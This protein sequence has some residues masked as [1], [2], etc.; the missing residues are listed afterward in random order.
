MVYLRAQRNS[1]YIRSTFYLMRKFLLFTFAIISAL[2]AEAQSYPEGFVEEQITE[3]IFYP[4]GVLFP[5]TNLVMVW[6]LNGKVWLL[7]N[8][9]L[10]PEPIIDLSE[11]VGMWGDH[12]MIGAAL[13]PDFLNNGWIYLFYVVDRHYLMYHG[14][15]EYDPAF[16]EEGA[17]VMGRITRFTLSTFDFTFTIPGSRKIIMG[18]SPGDGLPIPTWSHGVG[19]LQFGEDGSLLVS[20]GD[21]NTWVG[22]SGGLGYNGTGP[23]PEFGMDSLGLADGLLGPDEML[24]GYRAQYLDGL[25]GKVLRLHPETGEGLPNNPF[26]NPSEPDGARSKV[27]ALGLRNPY[28]MTVKEGTGNGGL[29]DGFPGVIYVSDVGDWVWEET[30]VIREPGLNFGWPMFQGPVIHPFYY[31][32]STQNTNAPNPLF[33]TDG[34]TTPFFN[35]QRTVLPSNFAHDYVFSNPC[36]PSQFIPEEV[37]T[38]VHERPLLAYA[39]EANDNDPYAVYMSYDENGN[40]SF[41]AIGSSESTVEG[42]DF[43]GLS[44]SGGTFLSGEFIPEEQ[45]GLYLFADFTGWIR[46]AHVSDNDEL[47]KVELWNEDAGRPLFIT[48]NPFNGCIYYCSLFPS[49]VKKICF[50]GNRKPVVEVNPEIVY[51]H[52]PLEVSFSTEGSYDPEGDPLSFFWEFCDGTVSTDANPVH[53]FYS[54]NEVL[55]TCTVRVTVSDTSG[56]FTV[57]DVFVSLNNTPP[58]ANITSIEEGELYS[59]RAP[60]TMRLVAEVEDAEHGAEEMT[61]DWSLLLHHNTH[62]HQL[63]TMTANNRTVEINPTGC[64]QFETYWYEITLKVTDPGGLISGDTRMI[65]PDCEGLLDD[66]FDYNEEPFVLFPNPAVDFVEIRSKEGFDGNMQFMIYGIDGRKIS[67]GKPPVSNERNYVRLDISDFHPGLFVIQFR[68]GDKWHRSAFV[69]AE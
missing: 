32:N 26:Y 15:E 20:T 62:F 19:S 66:T 23:V 22:G 36:D 33:N 43:R 65:Y 41:T 9:V 1:T 47:E 53:T 14:T 16:T 13:H 25:N 52:S 12:G 21:G 18:E 31:N 29:E 68:I 51:G 46:A 56:A 6:E 55:E 61:Y 3:T 67:E 10:H 50:G 4:G 49:F 34:C 37:I 35:Y 40:E 45:Q 28:R 63:S 8:E 2:Y 24:G 60:T 57:R 44:T 11:E 38:F 27:Y 69:K 30:N 58:S 48:Q 39:N 17:P 64:S 7:E 42:E 59:I 54:E 5:D